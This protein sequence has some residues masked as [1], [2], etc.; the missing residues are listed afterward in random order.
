MNIAWMSILWLI[1]CATRNPQVIVADVEPVRTKLTTRRGHKQIVKFLCLKKMEFFDVKMLLGIQT[2]INEFNIDWIFL[3]TWLTTYHNSLPLALYLLEE[4]FKA[5][6]LLIVFT[7]IKH[8]KS[9]NH[10][11]R[12]RSIKN[13]NWWKKKLQTIYPAYNINYFELLQ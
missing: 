5:S 9:M 8:K 7:S 13:F 6:L 12:N 1:A 10:P 4:I 2:I 11:K 3:T